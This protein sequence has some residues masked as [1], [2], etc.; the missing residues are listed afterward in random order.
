VGESVGSPALEAVVTTAAS[1]AAVAA[2]TVSSSSAVSTAAAIAASSATFRV[3]GT[4]YADSATLKLDTCHLL[5]CHICIFGISEGHECEA[6]GPA[7]HFVRDHRNV[8]QSSVLAERVFE[9]LVR[10]LQSDLIF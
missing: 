3:S 1:A 7:G 6:P 5:S 2:I 10:N 8:G 4:V 9:V